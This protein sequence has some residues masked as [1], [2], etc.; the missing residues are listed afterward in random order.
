MAVLSGHKGH[1]ET[2]MGGLLQPIPHIFTKEFT[3]WAPFS[4]GKATDCI[5]GWEPGAM[6]RSKGNVER[7]GAPGSK[8][9]H[10]SET[11]GKM[12]HH[13]ISQGD[14]SVSSF[15]FKTDEQESQSMGRRKCR[16]KTR[17]QSL[18][19][20]PLVQKQ[21]FPSRHRTPCPCNSP[22]YFLT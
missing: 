11:L 14:C 10:F 12:L 6:P 22:C 15:N 16:R 4:L 1:I 21:T 8:G 5:R 18:L 20:G 3:W 9:S 19:M 13:K 7:L 2:S 17:C